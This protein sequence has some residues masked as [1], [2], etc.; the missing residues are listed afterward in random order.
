MTAPRTFDNKQSCEVLRA[1]LALRGP[2]FSLWRI[3]RH[4]WWLYEY[5]PTDRVDAKQLELE[6]ELKIARFWRS[7]DPD[8]IEELAGE[9]AT[10]DVEL[11]RRSVGAM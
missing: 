6:L 5:A 10:L 11:Y 9:L 2:P 7:Q 8:E 4:A 3:L 1:A